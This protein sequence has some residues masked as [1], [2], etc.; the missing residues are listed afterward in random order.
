MGTIHK[1]IGKWG[2]ELKWDG[3]RSRVYHSDDVGGVTETWMIGKPEKAENFA[4]RYYKVEVGGNSKKEHHPHDHGILFLH[5]EG[6]VFLDGE[7]HT[8]S[9]GDVVYIPP[10]IEHQ[11]I[12]TGET[13]LGFLCI[14]PARRK[15]QGVEVWADENIKFD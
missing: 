9:Q 2:E 13:P 14:I 1:F 6:K 4:M 11:I 8:I 15:K 3:A 10:N 12:N 7:T 5:G